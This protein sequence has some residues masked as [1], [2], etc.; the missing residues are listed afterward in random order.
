MGARD[1]DRRDFQMLKS[2]TPAMVL[3][4]GFVRGFLERLIQTF[5]G[6]EIRRAMAATTPAGL[7]RRSDVPL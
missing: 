6:S 1:R 3:V 2:L 7:L 4:I 5:W